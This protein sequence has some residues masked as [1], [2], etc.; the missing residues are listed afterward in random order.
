MRP[1]APIR[2]QADA[3]SKLSKGA[4]AKSTTFDVGKT[5]NGKR[6]DERRSVR[7]ITERIRTA[8]AVPSAIEMCLWHQASQFIKQPMCHHRL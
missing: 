6:A 2:P 1:M 8:D 7:T 3:T 5:G 4:K